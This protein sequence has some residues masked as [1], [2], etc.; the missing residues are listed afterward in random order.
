[1]KASTW[2]VAACLSAQ[3]FAPQTA[4]AQGKPGTKGAEASPKD[5]AKEFLKS[6][7]RAAAAGQ[8]ED[9]YADYSIAWTMYQGWETALGLGKSASK[10]GHHAEAFERLSY[11]LRE[12]PPK[13]V[14]PKQRTEIDA[15]IA[16]AKGKTGTFTI[17]APEG[18]EVFLDR[19]AVGKTPLPAAI[20]VDPGKHE[21]EV[22]RG[23]AGESRA[24]EVA[25]GANVE[26]KFEP[27]KQAGAGPQKIVTVERPNAWRTPVLVTGGA[28]AVAGLAI[29][30]VFL[31]ISFQQ[32]DAKT[33]AA[34]DPTGQE[35]A[36]DAA[37]AEAQ[38]R[39]V[40]LWSFVGAGVALAGTTAVFFATRPASGPKVQGAVGVGQG[41]PAVW[42]QGEF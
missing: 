5:K 22:R 19:N 34:L 31:G 24:I 9:A 4:I 2:V 18:G 1:M 39:N 29:G 38:A 21:I 28:L 25:A 23:T 32:A 10:T 12:A 41:G 30:G 37:N 20:R 27:P 40:M 6:G 33:K 15:M 3:V 36:L 26:V 8:W 11:Y 17:V 16:D 42:I 14:T 13:N 7:D 35:A